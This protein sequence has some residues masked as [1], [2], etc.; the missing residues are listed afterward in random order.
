M[1]K[2]KKWTIE[3]KYQYPVITGYV[4]DHP[5]FAPGYHIVT[6]RVVNGVAVKEG[7]ILETYSGSKYLC[8]FTQHKGKSD[9]IDRLTAFFGEEQISYI[10]KLF[11]QKSREL[12]VKQKNFIISIAPEDECIII[13]LNDTDYFFESILYHDHN[14]DFFSKHHYLHLGLYK[15]SVLIGYPEI[16]DFRFYAEEKAISFYKFSS[17][18]GPVY[19]YN[20]G[21]A[22]ITVKS[23]NGEFKI[24]PGVLEHI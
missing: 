14:H 21:Q 3:K 1:Y 20:A 15:D 7:L 19:I 4:Y 5:D 17:Q 23:P 16:D 11:V 8:D 18:F 10:K 24:R 2:F 13:S 12:F 6:S 22:F 9:D